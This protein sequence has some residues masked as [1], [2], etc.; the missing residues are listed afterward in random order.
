VADVA[1]VPRPKFV[2][3]VEADA[4]SD[5]FADFCAA[6]VMRESSPAATVLAVVP[7]VTEIAGVVPPD[8]EIG[9][10]PVTDV[11]PPAPAGP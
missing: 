9:A 7:T 11:T 4:K 5:R 3:A 1:A 2:R 6:P 10:V 8:E